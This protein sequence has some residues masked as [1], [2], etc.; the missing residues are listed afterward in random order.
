MRVGEIDI[1]PLHDGTAYFRPTEAFVGTT[2]E[3]WEP[4]R[5]LLTADGMVELELGGFLVRTGD[6]VVLV[7]TG[8][9]TISGVFSGGAFLESLA[10]H[11]LTPDDVTALRAAL[12][13]AP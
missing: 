8:V 6:H 3:Q 11:G 13:A 2:D 9:G 12:V 10:A 1:A 4:H 5:A 7:D